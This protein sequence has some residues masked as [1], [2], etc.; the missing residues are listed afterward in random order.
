MLWVTDHVHVE[1]AGLVQAVYDMLWWDSYGRN[2]EAGARFNDNRDQIIQLTLCVVVASK[3][4][5]RQAALVT[6]MMDLAYFVFLAP[7]PTCGSSKSTP[8]GALLS[9]K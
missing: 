7:A 9:C 1:N 3:V 4:C 2:E 8:K 6:G 5:Q